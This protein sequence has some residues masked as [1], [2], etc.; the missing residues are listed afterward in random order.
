MNEISLNLSKNEAIVLLAKIEAD[1]K[2]YFTGERYKEILSENND[3]NTFMFV[4]AKLVLESITD[5]LKQE[6][7]KKESNNEHSRKIYC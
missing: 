4:V 1:L 3:D 2:N 5:K 7:N 6:L